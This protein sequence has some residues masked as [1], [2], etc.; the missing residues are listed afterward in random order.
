MKKLFK[1]GNLQAK[2]T[3]KNINK[4]VVEI[5]VLSWQ[6]PM[7]N[8]YKLTPSIR[9]KCILYNDYILNW[10]VFVCNKSL[11]QNKAAAAKKRISHPLGSGH[12]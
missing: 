11:V 6:T 1:Y 2:S 8:P 7:Q 3:N 10:R 12:A 4:F 5:S 9:T